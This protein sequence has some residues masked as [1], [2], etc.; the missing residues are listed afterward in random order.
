MKLK[1]DPSNYKSI[2]ADIKSGNTP[3]L[4]D[5]AKSLGR[6]WLCKHED[7]KNAIESLALDDLKAMNFS[8]TSP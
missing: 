4:N 8:C 7:V 3:L 6:K 2:L 1:Y 5:I